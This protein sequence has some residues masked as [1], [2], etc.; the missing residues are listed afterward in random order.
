MTTTTERNENRDRILGCACDLYLRDGLEGFSMRKLAREVGVTAPAIYRHYEG[1]EALLLDVVKEAYKVMAQHLYT[2]LSAPTPVERFRKAGEA[3]LDFALEH[4]RFYEITYSYPQL[5][6]IDEPP[7]EIAH[8][9][10]AIGQFWNDRVRECIDAGFLEDDD[11]DAVSLS[12]WAHSHGLLSIYQRGLL[13]IP[14]EGFRELFRAQTARLLAG[15]GSEA[16]RAR[17]RTERPDV[18]VSFRFEEA[19]GE[20][21]ETIPEGSP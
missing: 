2:A 13:P 6:G 20:R 9:A 10:C 16:E 12:F 3:Y 17:I 7:D 5:L 4:P 21:G 14:E 19:P 11:P 8:L 18:P 1:K 15:V